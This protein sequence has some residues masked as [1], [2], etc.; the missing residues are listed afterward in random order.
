MVTLG[1]GAAMVLGACQTDREVTRPEPEPVT[2]ELVADALLT[3]DDLPEGWSVDEAAEVDIA[4]E[5][6]PE[7]PCDDALT[8]LAPQEAATVSFTGPSGDLTSTVA[9]FPG[10]G[11]AVEQL[12]RD[13]AADCA[14]VVATDAGLSLRTGSLD[15]GV[16]SDDTLALRFEVEPET[17][18]IGE[19]DLVLMREGDL[20]SIIRLDGPRPSDKVLLDSVVRTELGRLGTL[21]NLATG[22]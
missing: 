1:L 20:V 8:E 14:A 9:Y 16:L 22:S 5:V 4:T 21:S 17:G 3:L 10:Q 12:V 7:H 2:E 18:P 6:L 15:F 13:I 19:R 11:G